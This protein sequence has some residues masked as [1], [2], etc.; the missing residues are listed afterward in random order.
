[1]HPGKY[2]YKFIVDGDWKTDPANLVSENDGMGNINSVY[3]VPNKNLFL[4]GYKTAKSVSVIGS[5]SNWTRDGIPM[6]KKEGGWQTALYLEQGTHYYK[7][8]VDGKLISENDEKQSGGNKEKVAFGSS[9]VFLLKGFTNA[10]Q[11]ALAGDFNDW[12]PDEIFM[13]PTEDGW[14]IPYVLGPGNYQYKY[15]VDGRWI[16]DPANPNIVSDGKGNLNSFRVVSPNF[17]FR[18]K[19]YTNASRVY[20]AGDFNN[21]SPEGLLMTK[22]AMNGF[23]RF[24]WGK[25]NT[26]ISLLSMEDGSGIPTILY[27]RIMMKIAFFGLNREFTTNPLLKRQ[28]Q[29]LQRIN[30]NIYLSNTVCNPQVNLLVFI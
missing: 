29:G 21:W 25:V 24:T 17:T 12:K 3:F 27:G 10:R 20:L 15:I 9:S 6:E 2:Y 28:H 23:R 18:L 30:R 11:V 14:R 4:K 26:F 22:W 13:E 1:L 16:T 5:F 8:M 19:G 7:F